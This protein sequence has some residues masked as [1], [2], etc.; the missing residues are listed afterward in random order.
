MLPAAGRAERL[1][2]LTGSK[3]L[4]EVGGRPVLE[5]AV[6]RMRAAAPDEIRVVTRPDKVDVRDHARGLG[7]AVVEAEPETLSESIAAGAAGLAAEDV[8]LIGLPDSIWH[9]V[10][11]FA[12]LVRNL[13]PAA[14][15]VLAVFGSSEPERGDVVDVADGVVR[16]V[17]VKPREPAGDLVWGAVAAR[18][19]CLAGLRL[20][21]EPGDLFDELARNGRVL[22]VRFPGEF[23]DIGTKEALARA[24][25]ELS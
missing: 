25:K 9:P 8:V 10:D 22:A 21:R 13:S 12:V 3:E 15:L 20:H 17:A 16:G 14:D 19:E 4:L 11:G 1:Q 5:Y 24:R 18:A 7:L 2:P 6:E 23:I